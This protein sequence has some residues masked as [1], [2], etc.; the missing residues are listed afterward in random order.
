MQYSSFDPLLKINNAAIK[1]IGD[2]DPPMFKYLGRFTQY[3]LKDDLVR[4][5][6]EAKLLKWLDTIE[7]SGLDGRMKAWIVNFHVCSKLAWLLMVQ[8]FRAGVVESWRDHIHRKFRR[9]L[10]LRSVQ[11]HRFST[12]RMNTLDSILKILFRWR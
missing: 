3:D 7:N 8:D 9:G 11:S 4:K 2:D 10:A 12:A 5:Q 6:V 1:F